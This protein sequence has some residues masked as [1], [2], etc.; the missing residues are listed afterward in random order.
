MNAKKIISTYA[1]TDIS[2]A[3]KWYEKQKKGLGMRFL[4][5][6]RNAFDIICK[7]PK[8]FQI[9]YD[10]YRIYYTHIF[11]YAI[12]YQFIADKNEIHIKAVF[13]TA[14]NPKI[15]QQRN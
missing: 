7:N 15:W 5:E 6:M 8:G 12:H 1:K 14:R 9:Y 13:H 10:D 4:N 2:E 11:P 3:S